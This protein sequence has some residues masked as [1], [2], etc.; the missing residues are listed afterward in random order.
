MDRLKGFICE[1]PFNLLFRLQNRH[2]I[3]SYTQKRDNRSISCVIVFL[4]QILPKIPN[5]ALFPYEYPPNC[6]F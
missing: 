3:N 1:S 5:I 2:K 4:K 6:P